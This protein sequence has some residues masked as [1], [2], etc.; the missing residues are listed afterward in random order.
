MGKKGNP[1][2]EI[3]QKIINKIDASADRIIA[4][5]EEIY[6]SAEPGFREFQTAR[7]VA[8]LFKSLHLPTEEKIAVTGV[9]ATLNPGAAHKVS[10]I[11]E[12]DGI[13][14]ENHPCVNV[15]NQISHACGHNAQLAALVGAAIALSDPEV[16]MSLGGTVDFL[17]VPAEEYVEHDVKMQLVRDGKVKYGIGG[18]SEF[19]QLG[20]FD[21]T[22]AV[23]TH[24]VHY[25]NT[26]KDV[27]IGSNSSNGF[28]SKTI[29]IHGKAAHAGSA[30]WDGVNALNAAAIGLNA[31]AYQ[32]ETFRDSDHVRVHPIMTH[33]GEV[34]NAVP[35]EAVIEMMVRAKTIAAMEDANRKTDRA[36]KA[37]ALAVGAEIEI[38]DA[39]GYLPV[40][41]TPA[42][43]AMIHVAELLSG[44][45]EI[46]E[47][48]LAEHNALSTDVGDINHLMP[49]VNFTTGGFR[50]G[51]HQADFE[52]TD[53][54]K[55]YIIPAK[56]M[57]L[58]AYRL[59][60][61]NGEEVRKLKEAFHPV[62]TK[63]QY[64]NHL[65]GKSVQ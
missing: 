24:H 59:L 39:P 51:L 48:D 65:E 37:G 44:E 25:F 8:D 15:E 16:A 38:E 52:I 13:K 35:S 40:I 32:R 21:D 49:V 5:A 2:D 29:R 34:V 56:I 41:A 36:F 61:N 62:L 19:I 33:G 45:V 58:T 43:P 31:L 6:R 4:F 30:P 23:I 11:G 64:F 53:K 22:D 1:M 14:C 7:K 46:G 12:L 26:P 3:E 57:A 63:E 54:Y 17:A 9:K 47:V 10:L 27:L 55:A 20:V 50:G 18:K 42:S 60:Q 28:I